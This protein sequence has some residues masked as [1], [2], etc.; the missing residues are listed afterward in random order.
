M[1]PNVPPPLS[2]RRGD[3]DRLIDEGVTPFC[4]IP[5]LGARPAPAPHDALSSE[6]WR[7]DRPYRPVDLQGPGRPPVHR[8]H[9]RSGPITGE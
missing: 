6:L 2:S 8:H 1:S 7:P 4:S 3:E 5:A 9:R